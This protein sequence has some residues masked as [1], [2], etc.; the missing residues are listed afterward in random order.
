MTMDQH[1]EMTGSA[2]QRQGGRIA[3]LA[4]ALLVAGVA[5]VAVGCGDDSDTAE[6]EADSATATI[7]APP[8]ATPSPV[9]SDEVPELATISQPRVVPAGSTPTAMAGADLV[10]CIATAAETGGTYSFLEIHIPTTSG[11][12]PHQHAREDEFFFVITGTASIEIGD[13]RAE[14]GPGDYFHVPKGT[15]HSIKA[16]SDVHLVAGYVPGGAEGPLF[17]DGAT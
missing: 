4:V 10:N 9:T 14:V 11:P 8:A 6:A 16:T 3:R 12:P 1:V 2:G 13:V 17:C 5:L 7:T 15:T